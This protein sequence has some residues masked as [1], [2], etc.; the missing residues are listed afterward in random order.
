MLD[1]VL[2]LQCG[3]VLALS[4]SGS[5]GAAGARPSIRSTTVPLSARPFIRRLSIRN[6]CY[7]LVRG[8]YVSKPEMEK[9]PTRRGRRPPQQP[10]PQPLRP[11]LGSGGGGLWGG[12]AKSGSWFKLMMGGGV[13]K[14]A[15]GRDEEP[16]VCPPPR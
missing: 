8:S 11:L 7:L 15:A 2:A 10:P 13:G 1:C 12:G 16:Q 4:F 3:G 5:S 14:G 6:P 9:P